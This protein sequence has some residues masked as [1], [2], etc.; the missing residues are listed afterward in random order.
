MKGAVGG[1]FG[2][3]GGILGGAARGF[4]GGGG[5]G[6]RVSQPQPG[7]AIA[8]V[9][10]VDAVPAQ[11]G[12]PPGFFLQNGQCTQRVVKTPG[13]RGGIERLLPGGR[14]GFQVSG[15]APT[16]QAVTAPPVTGDFGDAVMGQFGA[17]LQPAIRMTDVRVCPR[18]T[19]LGMDGLCYNRRDIRNSERFWPRGRRPLLTGG[20]MRCI[21][22]A[23]SAAK[24][25]KT[26]TKQLE[27]LGLLKKPAPR[28]R[29]L[30]RG[31]SARL[32]HTSEHN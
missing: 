14:T 22:V 17:A 19:V 24:K 20:E 31:H 2:G 10:P 9:N 29:A 13:F 12:C 4:I 15:G 25:L 5:N 1:I 7:R 11:T 16:A 23:A 3:P 30:P 21:T 8:L 18:G 27:T 26:K 6:G 32:A 28:S